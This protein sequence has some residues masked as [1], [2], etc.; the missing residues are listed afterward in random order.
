L[1]TESALEGCAWTRQA[2]DEAA[3]VM[4]GEGTPMSDQRAS[5]DYRTAMLGQALRKL[6]AEVTA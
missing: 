6:F 5:A 4:A 3:D 2:I 1:A